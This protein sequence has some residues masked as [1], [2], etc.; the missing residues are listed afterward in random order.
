MSTAVTA[1]QQGDD[2]QAYHFWMLAAEMLRPTAKIA[3]VGYEVGDYKSFDD[4][5]V[6]YSQPRI[7]GHGIEVD[8]DYFQI[9]FSVNYGKAITAEAL[10]DPAFS[11]AESISFL[12]RLRDA[13][14][15]MTSRESHRFVLITPRHPDLND[16]LSGLINTSDGS[17][18]CDALFKGKT[19]NSRMGKVRE[20]WA[21]KLGLKEDQEL[22]PILQ[23]LKIVCWPENLQDII[24]HLNAR[25]EAAGLQ[26]WPE[27]FRANPYPQLIR[28]LCAEGKTWFT[29]ECILKAATREGLLSSSI[30]PSTSGTYLG[31][32]TFMRWAESMEDETD[33][34]LCMCRHF[35]DRHIQSPELWTSEIVPSITNFLKGNVKSG[36]KY[37]IDLQALTSVAFLTG[38]LLDPKLN[39]KVA[40]AQDR[41][42]TPWEVDS[43]R[44]STVADRWTE[45]ISP[46][47]NG[48]GLAIGISVSRSV[49]DDVAIYIQNTSMQV[50]EVVNLEPQGGPGQKA[51][52]DATDAYA[53]AQHMINRISRIRKEKRVEGPTHIFLSCPNAFS[54]F[55][56]QLSRPLGEIRLYEFDFGSGQA[57]AYTPSLGIKYELRL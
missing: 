56:G 49:R 20:L 40:I 34:M 38:Y 12:E 8:A 3:E 39:V 53:L 17:I 44:I 35:V 41:S 1:R 10:V 4:V 51:I 13:V 24:G 50:Q 29:Q 45:N 36:G 54:F 32:R 27:A 37:V 14:R 2:Y 19:K 42:S 31:I 33:A 25:L 26:S 46:G 21:S 11:G 5:A 52:A 9:K 30:M 47:G 55:L 28:A 6:K 18:N 16:A 15:K 43:S 23:R 57:G 22:V 7:H 48:H